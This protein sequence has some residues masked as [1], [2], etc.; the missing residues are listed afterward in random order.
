MEAA[1]ITLQLVGPLCMLQAQ[2]LWVAGVL[3]Q[4]LPI[5]HVTGQLLAPLGLEEARLV[6]VAVELGATVG[7][8]LLVLIV[9]LEP[10]DTEEMLHPW[11]IVDT[12][13]PNLQAPVPQECLF[14]P[15]LQVREAERAWGC[16]PPFKAGLPRGAKPGTSAGSSAVD[17]G[18][19][20]GVK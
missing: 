5:V 6:C 1:Y 14:V 8:G 7:K 3:G 10:A 13:V 4:R 19:S 18:V 9:A 2:L 20:F 17:M 16:S 11:V 12:A 15:E